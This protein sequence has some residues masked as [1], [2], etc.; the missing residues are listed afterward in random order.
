MSTYCYILHD[1]E[2]DLFKIGKSVTPISRITTLCSDTTVPKYLIHRDMERKLHIKYAAQRVNHP[3][4]VGGRTE[5]FKPEGEFKALADKLREC[6]ILP[7]INP[8]DLVSKLQIKESLEAGMHLILSEDSYKIEFNI[9]IA[10]LRLFGY[11][12]CNSIE[13]E[14]KRLI[15]DILMIKNAIAVSPKI[16]E[17]LQKYSFNI[18]HTDD[19]INNTKTF[20]GNTSLCL[21]VKKL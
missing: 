10:I 19:N 7:Y 5:Y 21:V 6:D 8:S 9:G 15:G 16:V 2:Y 11:L 3:L 4:K 12:P 1:T 13:Q 20:F 18:H 14:N 17:H